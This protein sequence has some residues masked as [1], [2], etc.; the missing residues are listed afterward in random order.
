MHV[1]NVWWRPRVRHVTG[2]K[3]VHPLLTPQDV[4]P[5]ELRLPDALLD[6]PPELQPH[7]DVP[8]ALGDG[9]LLRQAYGG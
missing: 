8:Q 7:L 5:A 1:R 2:K 3:L 6:A 9:G 4:H